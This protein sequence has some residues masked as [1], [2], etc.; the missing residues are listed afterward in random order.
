M[1]GRGFSKDFL[2]RYDIGFD[3]TGYEHDGVVIGKDR[4]TFPVRDP[5]G[6]L[7]GF[8]RRAIDGNS[9]P[10]YL[11]AVP[12]A[13]VLYLCERVVKGGVLGLTEG[14]IDALR[15]RYIREQLPP[16]LKGFESF[17][18]MTATLG[19]GLTDG[20]ADL[21]V[22][23]DPSSVVLANDND[24]AGYAG[25]KKSIKMLRERGIRDI[26]VCT[27]PSHDL[28]DLDVDAHIDV[29]FVSTFNWLS[30]QQGL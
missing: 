16:E 14:P 8:T 24:A 6:R 4:V 17:A 21:V 27:F 30:R 13:F 28:G 10:K 19:A 5:R 12:K 25:T 20:Q 1:L 23:M 3:L 7:L 11:H 18:N 15:A 9:W 22:E 26:Q 29:D 2:R